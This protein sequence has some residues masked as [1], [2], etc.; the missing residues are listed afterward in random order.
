MLTWPTGPRSPH[1]QVDDRPIAFTLSGSPMARV[2][3][4]TVDQVKDALKIDDSVEDILIDGW[5]TS[6]RSLFEYTTERQIV[7]SEWECLIQGTPVDRRV[8]VPRPPMTQLVSVAYEDDGGTTVLID[9][10]DYRVTLSGVSDSASPPTIHA[11]DPYCRPG[12]IELLAGAWPSTRALKIRRV[13]GYGTTP[14][15][16]PP[17]IQAS[18]YQLVGHFYKYREATTAEIVRTVPF[19][20]DMLM[21]GFKYTAVARRVA[22]WR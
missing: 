4:V 15:E 19:G 2:E 20:V 22:A 3:P 1:L 6:A 5:I 14:A 9:P 21:A 13:C 16:I 10:S 11:L 8:E 7:T 18:L 17:L 12:A